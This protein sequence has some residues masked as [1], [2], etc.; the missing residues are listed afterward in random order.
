MSKQLTLLFSGSVLA[1]IIF[2]LLFAD[3]SAIISWLNEYKLL[4]QPERFTELYF[5]DHTNLPTHLIA[6]DEADF[7]FTVHNLEYEPFTYNYT[8]KA[9]STQSAE[10]L[11][12]GTFTLNHDEYK[13]IGGTIST[14]EAQIRTKINVSL[15]NKNQ[16]IH[17][18]VN[19][20]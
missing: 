19:G 2:F 1:V 14:Q 16:S 7:K 13:T 8:V 6:S 17:F 11:D 3:K 20:N 10:L 12:E 5:E 15:E 9:E 4:P 18:W